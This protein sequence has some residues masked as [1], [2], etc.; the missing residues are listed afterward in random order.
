MSSGVDH[1]NLKGF[2][3]VFDANVNNDLQDNIIEFFDWSL[4]NKGN[5]YNVTL[6]ESGVNEGRDLSKLRISSH[7]H[8]ASGQAW[9]GFR[10]NW[11]WQSGVEPP[12]GM[13][14][15]LVG[16]NEATPGLSGVY[17]NGAFY[18][19]DTAGTYA[20][21]VDYFHGRVIFDN[22]MPTG[23]VVQVPHSY[24]YI[25]VLYA[26][27]LPWVREIQYRTTEP[28]SFFVNQ[29]RGD[30]NLPAEARVQLPAI[31]VEIVPRRTMTGYQLG[32]GQYINT[33]VIFHCI[34]EDSFTRNQL[35]D[36][37]SL[38][39]EKT[40]FMF[41]SELLADSGA[42]PLDY[43]GVPVSGALTYP[44]LVE[45]YTVRRLR[46]KDMVVQNMDAINSNL[47][48]GIVRAT[49]EIIKTNI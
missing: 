29:D 49:A 46:L 42:F 9:E 16:T 2:F 40:I 37:V 22:V 7:P 1:L 17:V 35:V 30:F 43:R 24:K 31:A 32:G 28:N 6:A 47:Y 44:K 45:N 27:N 36:I 23:T 15:P 25:S 34:A 5:Y 38:Q 39:N 18:A 4:L 10:K 33:D 3:S 12:S 13:D 41:G 48:G 8:Y 14:A 26:S 19:S 20:H 21:N 11:V